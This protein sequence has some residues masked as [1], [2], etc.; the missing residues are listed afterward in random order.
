MPISQLSLLPLEKWHI[1]YGEK[2]MIWLCLNFY[3][4]RKNHE[5]EASKLT[6][7]PLSY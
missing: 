2:Y 6:M 3:S 1:I 7:L 4:S 5:L